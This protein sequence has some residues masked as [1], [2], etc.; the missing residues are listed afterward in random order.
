MPLAIHRR[1][2][3][4]L[5]HKQVQMEQLLERLDTTT[6]PQIQFKCIYGFHTLECY[7]NHLSSKDLN[8]PLRCVGGGLS[9]G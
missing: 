1:T 5:L 2:V 7:L 9:W 8:T 4:E 6:G 3:L